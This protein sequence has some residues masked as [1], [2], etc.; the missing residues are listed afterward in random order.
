[1]VKLEF[2]VDA[3]S[4]K[5]VLLSTMTSKEVNNNQYA[6][7]TIAHPKNAAAKNAKTKS[8]PLHKIAAV[9]VLTHA[10]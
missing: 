4:T 1:M 8:R 10:E 6:L 2:E 9:P 3:E 5:A 7:I